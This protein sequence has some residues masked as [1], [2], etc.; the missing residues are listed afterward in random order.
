MAHD[1]GD[2]GA[3]E[4]VPGGAQAAFAGDEQVGGLALLSVGAHDDGL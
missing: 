1:G 4:H 2:G 3:F